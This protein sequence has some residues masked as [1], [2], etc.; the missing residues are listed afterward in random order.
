MTADPTYRG[1]ALDAETALALL[2]WQAEL[3]ADEPCLDAA[4]DRYDL[5][6]RSAG[7]APAAGAAA[8][9]PATARPRDEAEDLT[10]LAEA[11]AAAA[12]DLAALSHA[13]EAFEGI[14]LRK[15]ARNFCFADGNPA[16][17]VMI[18]G[19]APGEEE[20][21]IGRP[22][23][24]RAGQLLDRMFDAIGLSRG[25]VDAEKALYITNV[26]PW[27]PPGNRRPEPAEIA[28]MLPFLRRHVELAQPDLLVL[29]GNT[30]CIAL[31]NQQG[32]L[33]LRGSW[34]TAFGL[35]A[36]PMTHPAYLLR[37]PLAKREAWA[38]LLSLSAR[39]EGAA[40]ATGT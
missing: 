37:T 21:R 27:R 13:Q 20:D 7:A 17:R 36:L 14:E 15:G 38:D 39:L 16:A 8:A 26:L 6:E 19:E 12:T 23:V 31:L 35:P 11:A 40:P 29:M 9:G 5:P 1:F 30:P 34:T 10:A 32:I 28:M 3:G 24:G 25:A 18:V 22:F 4:I 2:Q 33:K